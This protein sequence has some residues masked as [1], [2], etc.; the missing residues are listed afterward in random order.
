[1]WAARSVGTQACSWLLTPL[2][3]AAWVSSQGRPLSTVAAAA[4]APLQAPPRRSVPAT[5]ASAL[6]AVRCAAYQVNGHR[7]ER[8]SSR[9]AGGC[10]SCRTWLWLLRVQWHLHVHAGRR[11][12]GGGLHLRHA[13]CCSRHCLGRLAC[14]GQLRWRV[15][16]HACSREALRRPGETSS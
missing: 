10:L 4:Q 2:A 12:S 8:S 16:V 11:L 7:A 1:M 5:A 14:F 3:A 9:W 6:K 13:P 15:L